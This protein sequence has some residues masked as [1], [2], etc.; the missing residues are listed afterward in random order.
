MG[1]RWISQS[2]EPANP[3]TTTRWFS[4]NWIGTQSN[5]RLCRM[6]SIT[7]VISI[8]KTSCL[9]LGVESE[10]NEQSNGGYSL[11]NDR[12]CQQIKG[13]KLLNIYDWKMGCRVFNL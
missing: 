5:V 7:S 4:C 1:K 10:C 13:S 2:R 3:Y 8:G 11:R 9:C 6:C 12:D